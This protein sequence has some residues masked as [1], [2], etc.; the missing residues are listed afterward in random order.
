MIAKGSYLGLGLYTAREAAWYAR[1]P[2]SRMAAR[3][4]HG[5]STRPGV[6]RAEL[7]DDPERF[8][9][10]RDFAQLQA[11]RAIQLHDRSIGLRKIRE[12]IDWFERRYSVEFP[13][14]RHHR[15]IQ[16]G[17]D[18]WICVAGVNWTPG[19]EPVF[20]Q[21]TGWGGKGQTMIRNIAEQ[22]QKDMHYHEGGLASSF[23]LHR[24]G[25]LTVTMDPDMHFGQPMLSCGY[26][27]QTMLDAFHS[28]GSVEAA[29][30]AYGVTEQDVLLALNC[31]DHIGFLAA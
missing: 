30:R 23:T 16:H 5:T 6:I 18:L 4:V 12:S 8:I 14:A 2:S 7:A 24:E 25:E 21:A 20:E 13:L 28:E 19:A 3:W 22:Y 29:A 27:L 31:Q 15:L 11:I 26:S 1:I 9:T 10:F 17:K